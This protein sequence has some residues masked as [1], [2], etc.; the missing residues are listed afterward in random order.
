MLYNIT[1]PI[2]GYQTFQVEA[3]DETSAIA[4][5]LTGEHLAIETCFDVYETLVEG[6]CLNFDVNEVS[7]EPAE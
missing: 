1:V 7:V 6:N 4:A 5:A 3:E 2:A